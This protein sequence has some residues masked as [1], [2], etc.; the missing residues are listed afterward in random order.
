MQSSSQ[1]QLIFQI[2]TISLSVH[3][4][5]VLNLI[6]ESWIRSH[7]VQIIIFDLLSFV[8]P[9]SK[10]LNLFARKKYF[11]GKNSDKCVFFQGLILKWLS[12]GFSA[13]ANW[14]CNI[15]PFVK[16]SAVPVSA[17]LSESSQQHNCN[18]T[19]LQCFIAITA[20]VQFIGNQ[21]YGK[22]SYESYAQ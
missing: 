6:L 11:S 20:I 13:G 8:R 10:V 5:K 17:K 16:L 12:V 19:V 7:G 1:V 2:I 14:K 9:P 21:N 18:E 15:G 3:I 22:S 4:T